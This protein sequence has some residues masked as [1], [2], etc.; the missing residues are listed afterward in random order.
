MFVQEVA[1]ILSAR[2]AIKSVVI[3]GLEVFFHYSLSVIS[4]LSI[5][6]A[7][8]CV[9]QSAISFLNPPHYLQPYVPYIIADGVSSCNQFEVPIALDRMRQEGA[10][11]T[12]SESLAFQLVGSAS[13]PQFKP[14]SQLVR[15]QKDST[16]RVG[17]ALLP[18]KHASD[19]QAK[20]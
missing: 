16:T 3:F 11:I 10:I 8:V 12:T 2:P 15:D 17:E 5:L 14:F 19:Q 18:S 13:H 4:P 7:H 20:M 1:D 6:Q 9:L